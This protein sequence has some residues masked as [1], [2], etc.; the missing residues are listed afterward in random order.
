MTSK[1]EAERIFKR[2]RLSGPSSIPEYEQRARVERTKT[3]KL[4]LLR[5]AC[6]A[7]SAP[8][9]EETAGATEQRR[10]QKS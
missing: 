1:D 5:L 10:Q 3:A 7:K 6:E 8:K 4:R 9:P 2:K